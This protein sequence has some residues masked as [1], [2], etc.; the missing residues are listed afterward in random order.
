[1]SGQFHLRPYTQANGQYTVTFMR[2]LQRHYPDQRLLV[3]WDG[4]TYHRYGQMRQLLHTINQGLPEDQWK[5]YCVRLA[6]YA[7]QENPVEDVWL[8][9][10]TFVRQQLHL[11]PTFDKIKQLFVRA[12]KRERYFDFPKLNQY[13]MSYA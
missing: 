6:P 7:P 2:Y 1:M 8:K 5:I 4:A 3:F 9:A 13:T 11:A 10:K 12:I